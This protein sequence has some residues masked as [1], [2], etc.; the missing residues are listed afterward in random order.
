MATVCSFIAKVRKEFF[1]LS[2]IHSMLYFSTLKI[3]Q[4][5]KVC[6][7]I[8]IHVFISFSVFQKYDISYIALCLYHLRVYYGITTWLALSWLDS[9]VGRALTGIARVMDSNLL[10]VRI[11]YSCWG[12]SK[13]FKW[14]NFIVFFFFFLL[15]SN[16]T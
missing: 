5:L 14:L 4:L 6:I 11:F 3:P 13:C 12:G 16:I 9:S 15:T 2:F 1:Y 10:Q 7:L 8:I